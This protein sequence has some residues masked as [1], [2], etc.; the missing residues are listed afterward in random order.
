MK[1]LVKTIAMAAIALSVVSAC[2]T[3]PTGRNQL[4]LL[5]ASQLDQM[6]AESWNQIKGQEKILQDAEAQA[7][8]ACITNAIAEVVPERYHRDNWEFE[9]FDSETINAFALPGGYLGVY[10]GMIRLAEN[11]HQ[12]AAVM[13]HEIGHVMAE[14]SNER[15]SQ[16]LI[17]TGALVGT[18]LAF[19]NR[20]ASQRAMIMAAVGVGA[21]VG[22]MLPFSRRHESEADEIGM[23][24]MARAGFD[25]RQAPKLWENMQ[26]LGGG[27]GP[28]FLS[29]HPSPSSRIRDLTNQLPDAMPL[30]EAR[31]S[32]GN[33]PQC[34][35]PAWANE[36]PQ[37]S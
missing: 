5:P 26:S 37:Q 6:G 11:Q 22:Y 27:G 12:L 2:S 18:D 4:N 32:Q 23:D 7:Y 10:V 25:P 3:S 13:G 15:V 36:R 24:L 29:T 16:N 14:H 34:R 1:R 30:Y 9:I 8:V 31:S 20:S 21:Q 19:S 17:L 33:L 28:E 35:R